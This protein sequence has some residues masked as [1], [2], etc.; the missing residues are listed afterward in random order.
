MIKKSWLFLGSVV[1]MILFPACSKEEPANHNSKTILFWSIEPTKGRVGEIV[2]VEGE[3]FGDFLEDNDLRFNGKSAAIVT[4]ST[5]RLVVTV[6]EGATTGPI[7]LKVKERKVTS[8]MDF[9]VMASL[10]T[11]LGKSFGGTSN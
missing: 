11:Y 10:E 2:V 9:E 8:N 7:T 4:A 1:F 3:G 6:P 5:T